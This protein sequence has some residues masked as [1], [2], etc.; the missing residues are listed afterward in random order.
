MLEILNGYK[1]VQSKN[2]VSLYS[3]CQGWGAGS[4][5][6]LFFQA[7]TTPDF[8]LQADPAPVIFFSSGSGSKGFG[9]KK[10]PAPAHDYWLSLEK[11]SF[12]RKLVR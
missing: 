10:K 5:S 11:Y 2:H 1:N 6:R 7:A 8:F 3:L 9:P 4:G 12:P